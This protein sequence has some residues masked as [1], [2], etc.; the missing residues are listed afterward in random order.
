MFF[1]RAVFTI[2]A[3][4]GLSA[5]ASPAPVVVEKRQDVNE[6]LHIIATL[7]SAVSG[8]LPQLGEW[9]CFGIQFPSSFNFATQY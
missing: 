2:L 3:L 6:A 1:S 9:A 5:I 7:D 4:G 8:I